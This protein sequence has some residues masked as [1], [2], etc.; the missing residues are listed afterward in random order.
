MLRSDYQA[1][2]K[3]RLIAAIR[4]DEYNVPSDKYISYQLLSTYKLETDTVLRAGINRAHRSP[5]IVERYV[6]IDIIDPNFPEFQ[7]VFLGDKE[8]DL[9][10]INTI[11]LGFR[12]QFS[13]NNWM[14]I[15]VFHNQIEDFVSP[16]NTGIIFE[17]P[18]IIITNQYQVSP[19]K[20]E[21]IGITVDWRYEALNWDLNTFFTIQKTKITDQFT[22]LSAPLTLKDT[23]DNATPTTYGGFNANWHPNS[24]WSF[25][26]NLYFMQDHEIKLKKTRGSSQDFQNW[27]TLNLKMTHHSSKLVDVHLA[28]KNLSNRTQ[29]QYY[30]SDKIDPI[31]LLGIDM[32]FSD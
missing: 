11:E 16:V 12:H 5:F 29:S 20:A 30:R 24:M 26:S 4:Q 22:N 6:D 21:Q 28:L 32:R 14:D 13:F 25:N 3:L 23:N 19:T 31:L 18:S 7:S 1:S 15:E 10:T 9:T 27:F 8:M 17:A 2:S